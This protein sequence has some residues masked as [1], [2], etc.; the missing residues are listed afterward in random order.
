MKY[1]V[2]YAISITKGK[3]WIT[4][5]SISEPQKGDDGLTTV[6]VTYKLSASPASRG[7]TIH[8]AQTSGTLVKDI[9]IVQK[10]PDASPVEIPDAVLRALCISNGWA[11]PIDDT[12]CIILEEGLNATSFSNTSYSNQI[13]DL[14]LSLIHI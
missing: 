12:K 13:K 10:D 11:L 14:T 8:I 2:N 7:G 9:A 1:N 3:D 4:D 6:T 5:Q